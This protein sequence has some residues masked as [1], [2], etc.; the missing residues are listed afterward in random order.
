MKERLFDKFTEFVKSK[1]ISL[2]PWQEKAASQFLAEIEKQEDGATGKTFL[3][4][5]LSLFVSQ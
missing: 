4:E 3:L 2:S 5:Q 1:N